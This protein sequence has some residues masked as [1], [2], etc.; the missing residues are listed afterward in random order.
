MFN[1]V[2][3]IMGL[4]GSGKTKKLIDLINETSK[5]EHENI[6]CIERKAQLTY[7][8]PYTVRLVT[9]SDYNLNNSSKSLILPMTPRLKNLSPGARHFPKRK[10]SISQ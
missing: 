6:V 8:L 1:L 7:D 2:K 3:V 4:K 5:D 9:A 10:R